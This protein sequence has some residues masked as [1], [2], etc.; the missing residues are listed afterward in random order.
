RP[1]VA[2]HHTFFETFGENS[3]L[4]ARLAAVRAQVEASSAHS[5]DLVLFFHPDGTIHSASRACRQLFGLEPE[6]LVGANC[7]E[8]AHP[9]DRSRLAADFASIPYFG[10]FVRSEFRILDPTGAV[11]WLE[12]IATNVVDDPNVGCLVGNLRDITERK[13]A[14]ES[15]VFQARLL[16]A[17]GQ[18][19]IATDTD[20]AVTYWNGAAQATYGWTASEAIGQPISTILRP[21]PGWEAV[22]ERIR[23]QI[24]EGKSWMGELWVQ[25]K[26]GSTI[27]VQLTD[28]AIYDETGAAIGT[29]GVSSN[30]AR[31]LQSDASNLLLSAI[32]ESSQDAI[33]SATEDGIVL[34]WNGGA[35]RLFGRTPAE[36]IGQH[37][38]TVL[39]NGRADDVRH[40]FDQAM[41]G[42]FV[43][44]FDTRGRRSDGTDVN[45]SISVS[46]IRSPTG[47]IIGTSAIARDITERTQFIQQIE[48]DRRRLSVAQASAMLGSF[49]IDTANGKVTRSDEM[50]R[51]LGRNPGPATEL[52]YDHVHPDD[53]D[54]VRVFIEALIN[55]RGAMTSEYRILRPDGGV[56]WVL[57]R[58]GR[59]SGQDDHIIAGTMLDITERHDAAAAL[60][61]QATHD[62][63]TDLPNQAN[64]HAA[65]S[66][67]LSTPSN[68]QVAL[69]AIDLDHFKLI[70]DQSGH[71]VGDQTLRAV[72]DRLRARLPDSD[73]VARSGGDEFIAM[74]CDVD[75]ME[76][77]HD[78]A[79][80][81]AAALADPLRISD[82]LMEVTASIGV[83]LS[84]AADTPGSL[85]RDA[86]DAMYQAKSEGRNRFTLLGAASKAHGHRRQAIAA[87]LPLALEA[88]QFHLE[89]Q[90]VI[91]LRTDTVA[92]FEAL[93]RWNHPT[94]GVIR[95]DEFISVAEHTGVILPIGAWVLET[96]LAQ[97]AVWRADRRLP[98]DLWMALNVSAHQ[99]AQPSFVVRVVEAIE[100]AGVPAPAV[101]L[102]ITESILMNRIESALTIITE[103][104]ATGIK[105]SIDDFGTG[106]SSLSYLTKF[107]FQTLKIDR[108]FIAD[109]DDSPASM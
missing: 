18:A 34:T 10:D 19:V 28:T 96:A 17:V 60:A 87:A 74:R 35:A 70:N 77:A 6:Q 64:L 24:D 29:I 102:E 32:V 106:Y 53:R 30:I 52:A 12:E 31:R 21:V 5:S 48:A 88:G 50:W 42:Q 14:E 72:A 80:S 103:L 49:E 38:S 65:L 40:V 27:P 51:L 71:P 104:Q 55:G 67:A 46:P 109:L 61:Y 8:L 11:R 26:Q 37:L 69:A 13:V 105:V 43:D 73:V 68:G 101:H 84:T 91:D 57:S 75:G 20:G 99:L 82:R 15:V 93:I 23:P 56:R 36:V 79:V 41:A 62:W 2:R 16:A 81:V 47:E 100:G 78:F 44:N 89:Y 45:L 3:E 95:P 25:T 108:S 66:V 58:A 85:L 22:T 59:L 107:P 7:V 97:L 54:Q 9:A 86:D 90:P 98:T 83:T 33:F 76:G 94:L 1:T 63:L 4:V 39:P 92:G